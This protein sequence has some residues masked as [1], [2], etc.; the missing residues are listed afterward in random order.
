MGQGY[1]TPKPGIITGG[2]SL[3]LEAGWT[4]LIVMNGNNSSGNVLIEYFDN[5]SVSQGVFTLLPGK[6]LIYSSQN[7]QYCKTVITCEALTT[8]YYQYLT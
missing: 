7:L 4:N 2:S 8:A 3:T 6:D 5:L 1:L